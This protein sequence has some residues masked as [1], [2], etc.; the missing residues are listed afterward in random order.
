VINSF[1][2]QYSTSFVTYPHTHHILRVLA[3]NPQFL[4]YSTLTNLPLDVVNTIAECISNNH[5]ILI[6]LELIP[7]ILGMFKSKTIISGMIS[8]S[9]NIAFSPLFASTIL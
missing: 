3:N 9:F 8:F 6:F 1:V 7:F 5:P 4:F 2:L